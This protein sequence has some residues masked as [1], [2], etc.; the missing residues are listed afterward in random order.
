MNDAR[1]SSLT[2][3][4]SPVNGPR[5]EVW[6]LRIQDDLLM[7]TRPREQ[8]VLTVHVEE[9][10]RY[11]R[12]DY[13][14]GLGR[15]LSLSVA[16]GMKP[17]RF[18]CDKAV[19]TAL[20]N[21]LPRK[22]MQLG[23]RDVR[24]SGL[25]VALFGLLHLLLPHHLEAETGLLLALTGLIGALICARRVYAANGIA[26]IGAGLWDIGPLLMNAVP[27]GANAPG[28]GLIALATGSAMLIWGVQQFAMLSPNQELRL[29]RTARDERAEL[30]P[31]Q[32]RVIRAVSVVNAVAAAAF[33]GYS[34]LVITA[35]CARLG[36]ELDA[37]LP[38]VLGFAVLAL[39]ALGTSIAIRFRSHPPYREAKVSGQ[40]ILFVACLSVWSIILRFRPDAPLD[41]VG[42]IFSA[43]VALYSRP[44]IWASLIASVLL[45]NRWFT[46]AVD[47]ELEEQRL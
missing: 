19:V 38:D 29:A 2:I 18:R 12:F 10:A 30:R 15:T 47:R 45:F 33:G 22:D 13:C 9:A 36:A 35:A 23:R 34:V 37:A 43:D 28:S 8:R 3:H 7:L 4:L 40:L 46:R 21:A 25:A 5:E 42:G 31:Q 27:Q 20:L 24:Y 41:F 44:Y 26:L 11:V 14:V 39:A 32:S 1:T 16:E 6:T 17:Y